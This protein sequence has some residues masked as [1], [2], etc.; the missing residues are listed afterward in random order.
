[1]WEALEAGA[2]PILDATTPAGDRNVWPD[3]LGDHPLPVIEDWSTVGEILETKPPLV[4][5]WYTKYKRDLVA[6]LMDDWTALSGEEVWDPPHTRI[7]TIVTASPI[8]SNPG[9]DILA[10][11]VESVRARL[12]G[13]EIIIA[14]DGP[15]AP[16]PDYDEHIRR[17]SYHANLYW[18]EVWIHYT[19][20]WKHQAGTIKDVLPEVR[21]GALLMVE[22]DTPIT[23]DIDWDRLVTLI[24]LGEFNL[25]RLHYDDS[26]HPD[27][28]YLMRG[29]KPDHGFD[30]VKTVQWSQRPHV[31]L[32]QFY[33]DVLSQLPDEARTYVEDW[34]YGPV[35]HS[36]WEHH[37]LGIYAPKGM[38]RSYH[39]DGRGGIP[40]GEFW[41]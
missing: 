38:K 2:V 15:R 31:V 30:V 21:T 33:R 26:I 16:D 17:V 25:I 7:T 5:P 14:F 37:K 39:L 9:F 12:P 24:Y 18:P 27:H 23:G 10:E 34:I 13:H 20:R 6:K 28:K 41:W 1:M 32:T 8:P 19:G 11:T 29:V 40:K 3:T 35:A 4:G 36:P 22:A